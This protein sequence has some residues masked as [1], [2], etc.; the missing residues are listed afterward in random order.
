MAKF[1]VGDKVRVKLSVDKPKHGWGSVS[2][3]EVGVV[4]QVG[5]DITK[6]DFPNHTRWNA[7]PNEIELAPLYKPVKTKVS[8]LV[9]GDIIEWKGSVRMVILPTDEN[10]SNSKWTVV[11][12]GSKG[13]VGT[14]SRWSSGDSDDAFLHLGHI[15]EGFS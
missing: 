14:V 12:G 9:P 7:D 6:I 8:E 1:K 11:L 10:Y 4:S 15:S 3:E 5:V 13:S 2:A